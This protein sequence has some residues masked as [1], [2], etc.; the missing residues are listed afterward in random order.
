MSNV[1]LT[2]RSMLA[3]TAV[4]GLGALASKSI[5]GEADEEENA[6]TFHS[7]ILTDKKF[8]EELKKNP[9]A[10][11]KKAGIAVPEDVE[12]Q[13]VEASR[14]KRVIVLPPLSRLAEK[15]NANTIAAACVDTTFTALC[16]L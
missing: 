9:K 15:A 7:R 1:D 14:K 2:R 3:A 4:V 5:A 8:R 6:A 12:V 11:L 13:V 10:A 16:S